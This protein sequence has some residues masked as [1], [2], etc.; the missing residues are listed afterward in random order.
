M[1]LHKLMLHPNPFLS[2]PPSPSQPVKLDHHSRRSLTRLAS[3]RQESVTTTVSSVTTL[4]P[5]VPPLT[6]LC[7]R[8]LLT[9]TS[10]CPGAPLLIT[11][12]YDVPISDHW[13]IPLHIY[14]TLSDCMPGLLRPRK[15][16][17]MD[18]SVFCDGHLRPADHSGTTATCARREHHG[19]VFV[20]HAS[21]RYTWDKYIAGVDVGAPVPLR[22]RGCLQRCLDFLDEERS[23]GKEG[24]G[25]DVGDSML[26][27]EGEGE[28][29]GMDV[30]LQGVVQRVQ[31]G[32]EDMEEEF[33]D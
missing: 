2:P 1:T 16:C 18:E 30:D 23:D 7:F 10:E 12:Y 5:P 3:I 17:L 8:L 19:N 6:E 27:G 13:D 22:W 24:E 21:E 25:E 9:P 33:G 4:L 28:G 20:R 31:L 29:D 11:E 14:A 15:Q 32:D 26:E